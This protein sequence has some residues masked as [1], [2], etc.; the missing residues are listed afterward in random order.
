MSSKPDD[1]EAET[2]GS[3]IRLTVHQETLDRLAEATKQALRAKLHEDMIF[4]SDGIELVE[5]MVSERLESL[6]GERVPLG[7]RVPDEA[8]IWDVITEMVNV[9]ISYRGEMPK[10]GFLQRLVAGRRQVYMILMSVSMFGG[11]F[12]V[13]RTSPTIRNLFL[14]LFLC[15][16]AY[17]FSSWK[18]EDRERIEKELDRVKDS[19]SGEVRRIL[20]EVN[21]EKLSRITAYLGDITKEALRKI[22]AAVRD[23][24]AQHGTKLDQR[25]LE[26]KTRIKSLEQE[27]RERQAQGQSVAKLRQL[28]EELEMSCRT[29]R[30]DAARATK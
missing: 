2:R 17:T 22:D 8:E 21:R 13:S 11:A 6:C 19:L 16:V 1:L 26:L 30:R 7:L 24:T 9:E 23:V 27:K 29:A 5:E 4:L 25:R 10:R 14:V 12:G 20:T 15:G 3:T 18:R 28:V